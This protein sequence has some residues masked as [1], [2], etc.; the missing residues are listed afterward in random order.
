MLPRARL[1]LWAALIVA[2]SLLGGTVL[3]LVA[4][5]YFGLHGVLMAAFACVG[6]AGFIWAF[7]GK[8]PEEF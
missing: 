3:G 4:M 2:Y 8:Q 1:L 6:I 5:R 7:Q